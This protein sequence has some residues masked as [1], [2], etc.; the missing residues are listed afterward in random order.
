MQPA[1]GGFAH[2]PW[3][4]E[5]SEARWLQYPQQ[6]NQSPECLPIEQKMIK[7]VYVLYGWLCSLCLASQG[8]SEVVSSDCSEKLPKDVLGSTY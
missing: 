8:Q 3:L 5:K 4:S 7:H 2:E 1:D 6:C